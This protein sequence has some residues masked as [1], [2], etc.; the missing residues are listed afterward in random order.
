[1]DHIGW[2]VD[3]LHPKQLDD[4]IDYNILNP[5]NNKTWNEIHTNSN[6]KPLLEWYQYFLLAKELHLQQSEVDAMDIE[7]VN[8]YL[9]LIEAENIRKQKDQDQYNEELKKANQRR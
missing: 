2:H 8:W 4:E 5:E 7:Q 6:P 1:M 3:P 9:S